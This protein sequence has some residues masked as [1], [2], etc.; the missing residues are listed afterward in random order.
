MSGIS[1]RRITH[2]VTAWI[3]SFLVASSL[4]FLIHL[5]F[6]PHTPPHPN[7]NPT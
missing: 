1:Q 6:H 5:Q 3:A 2:S 4:A 7:P